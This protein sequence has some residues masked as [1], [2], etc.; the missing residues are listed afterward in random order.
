MPWVNSSLINSGK[1]DHYRGKEI[2]E[3]SVDGYTFRDL[4]LNGEF[5]IYEDSRG[6][7]DERA[8]DLLSQMALA[9]ELNMLREPVL[10]QYW[11]EKNSTWTL[12]EGSYTINASA[13]SRNIKLSKEIDL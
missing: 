11:S 2:K 10:E 9:E 7:I 4:N 5:D 6:S 13:S 3:I 12:E 1:K 8:E